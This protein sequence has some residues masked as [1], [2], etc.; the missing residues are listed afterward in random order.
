MEEF[1][2]NWERGGEYTL[3]RI[4][5]TA[6]ADATLFDMDITTPQF[7]PVVIGTSIDGAEITAYLFIP[8]SHLDIQITTQ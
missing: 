3:Q 8:Y 1:L 4:R 2:R 5:C 7:G 6:A